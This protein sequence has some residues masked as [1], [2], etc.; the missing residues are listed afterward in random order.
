MFK[1]NA[2]RLL[3]FVTVL[4]VVF[5][6]LQNCW[7]GKPPSE[8]WLYMNEGAARD[9]A[10]QV[11]GTGRGAKVPIPESLSHTVIK[12]YDTYVTFSPKN[13]PQ[14]ILAFSS[15]AKP[16]APKDPASAGQGWLPLRDSWYQLEVI[17]ASGQ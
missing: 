8:K 14:L 11:L 15:N 4:V 6:A 7:Q 17:P 12:T 16:P 5:F 3:I 1:M 13:D 10:G 9:Y 2:N